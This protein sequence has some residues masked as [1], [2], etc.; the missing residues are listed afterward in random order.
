MI[1]TESI[2]FQVREGLDLLNVN[3]RSNMI[4]FA[5]RD[6]LPWYVSQ[7]IFWIGSAMMLSWPLRVLIEYKTAHLQYHAH[8]LFGLNYS[9]PWHDSSGALEWMTRTGGSDTDAE[10]DIARNN[11]TVVPSYSE[12]LLMDTARGAARASPVDN[13]TSSCSIPR[14]LGSLLATSIL[15]RA[16]SY[17]HVADARQ[18]HVRNSAASLPRSRTSGFLLRFTDSQRRSM[19]TRALENRADCRLYGSTNVGFSEGRGDNDTASSAHAFTSRPPGVAVRLQ[20]GDEDVAAHNCA[21]NDR[22][23]N[24]CPKKKTRSHR[25]S[26]AEVSHMDPPGQSVYLPSLLS[27]PQSTAGGSA[28]TASRQPDAVSVAESPPCY[29]DALTM[30]LLP[31]AGTLLARYIWGNSD[32]RQHRSSGRG[33]CRHPT[34]KETAL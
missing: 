4:A 7:A 14:R 10:M 13:I 19:E 34:I 5:D 22:I 26:S 33:N 18:S 6:K 31:R 21:A 24:G 16:F 2:G 25:H 17:G 20:P 32:S 11:F 15:P 28:C 12:A 23:I 1:F 29:E 3:F 27:I 9:E 30:R 8:K